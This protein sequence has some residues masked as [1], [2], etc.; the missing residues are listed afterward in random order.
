MSDYAERLN[1]F[2]S[3]IQKLQTQLN[4]ALNR[5]TGLVSTGSSGSDEPVT[6]HTNLSG[7]DGLGSKHLGSDEY[8]LLDFFN[9][10]FAEQFNFTVTSNGTVITGSLEKT[11]T[12]DLT[13]QFA[14]RQYTILDCTPALTVTITPGTDTVPVYRYYYILE[15]AQTIITEGLSWPSAEHVKIAR[16]NVPSAAFAQTK[17][18]YSN[19]NINN[20][21]AFVAGDLSG[22]Y[23]HLAHKMRES[24]GATYKTVGGG[25]AGGA[26]GGEYL[27][28]SGGT[29]IR[30]KMDVGVVM[31]MHDHVFNAVDTDA[32]DVVLVRNF[33]GTAW[34]DI[35]NLYDIVNDSLGATINNKYFNLEVIALASKEKDYVM[36]NVPG[37]SYNTLAQAVE[38][39]DGFDDHTIPLEFKGVA[40]P[41][42]RMTIRKAASAWVVHQIDDQRGI[43]VA[44][45]TGATVSGGYSDIDAIAAYQSDLLDESDLVTD[46]HTQGATQGSIKDYVDAVG[47]VTDHGALSGLTDDDHTQYMLDSADAAAAEAAAQA[48]DPFDHAGKVNVPDDLNVAG[49]SYVDSASIP[50]Q[51]WIEQGEAADEKKV[52]A[53]ASSSDFIMALMN[54]AESVAVPFMTVARTGTTV[55]SV[56]VD[57][58]NIGAHPANPTDVNHLTDAQVTALSA[59]DLLKLSGISSFVQKIIASKAVNY[60]NGSTTIFNSTNG[61]YE[62][63]TGAVTIW[64]S[65]VPPDWLTRYV[66]EQSKTLKA[67]TVTVNWQNVVSADYINQIIIYDREPDVHISNQIFNDSTNLGQGSTGLRADVLNITDETL[68]EG[69]GIVLRFII[70]Q[71]TTAACRFLGFEVTYTIT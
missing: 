52:V 41:I 11:G 10:T 64:F 59:I 51:I 60:G 5:S 15:S 1:K 6:S 23:V 48:L 47:G 43:N 67:T 63:G 66:T 16:L 31:Q 4:Q 19:Q 58:V 9:S 54:D 55:D 56:T 27:D 34:N 44:A 28:V 8:L 26:G 36:I 29:T 35:S 49:N 2:Q 53:K 69:D 30:F 12:G 70:Q 45:F 71:G 62:G 68:N 24:V 18:V 22:G 25:L 40:T 20:D 3:D 50:Q 14:N 13:M 39:K 46:S 17:N 65:I 7:V 33:S 57:G 38:D 61:V 32:G 37:G 42:C 21:A